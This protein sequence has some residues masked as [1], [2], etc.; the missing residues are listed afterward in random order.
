MNITCNACKRTFADNVNF[1]RHLRLSHAHLKGFTCAELN[2]QKTFTILD[3]FIRHIRQKH[4][5][6][7]EEPELLFEPPF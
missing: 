6:R 3:T 2:C 1:I 7:Q 4:P 5:I